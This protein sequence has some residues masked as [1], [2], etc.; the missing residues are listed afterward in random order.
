[1]DQPFQKTPL[2]SII[3]PT[4][5]HASLI[6]RALGSALSQSFRDF[7]IIVIDDGST[8]NTKE[9]VQRFGPKVRYFYQENGGVSSARNHGLRVARGEYINFLDSDDWILPTKL[10]IQVEYLQSH[11]EIDLVFCN[12]QVIDAAGRVI[13]HSKPFI[14]QQFLKLILLEGFLGSIYPLVPLFKRTCLEKTG[15]FDERLHVSEEQEFWARMALAGY[16]FGTVE[17]ILCIVFHPVNHN[18]N[19]Y[20]KYLKTDMPIILEKTFSNPNIPHDVLKLKNEFYI[21]CYLKFAAIFYEAWK[22][23]GEIED[24]NHVKSYIELGLSATADFSALKADLF[25]SLLHMAMKLESI[26]PNYSLPGVI[27]RLKLSKEVV[28]Y[29][30]YRLQIISFWSDYNEHNF[31]KMFQTYK[32]ISTYNKKDLFNRGLLSAMMKSALRIYPAT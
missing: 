8:D 23:Y 20:K 14:P 6:E 3:I 5:N 18:I 21:S 31:S 24:L 26:D 28:S 13:Y 7:E 27:S 29:I 32:Q 4:Y 15:F 16:Q 9:I 1:M 10:T 19:L 11:P 30:S 2:V 12:W 17:Q 25:D 22:K